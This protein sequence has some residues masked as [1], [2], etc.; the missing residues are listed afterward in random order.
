M[1]FGGCFT[2]PSRLNDCFI[3]QYIQPLL[4]NPRRLQGAMRYLSIGLDFK[5]ID[6]LTEIHARIKVPV[7]FIWGN[8]DPTFPIGAARDMLNDFPS[9]ATMT[10]IE[11]G[12]L[13][14]HEEFPD[15]V[16]MAALK[17]LT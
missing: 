3:A 12:K 7:H 10:E 14:A 15:L 9:G 16:A 13:L 1:G 17:F 8:A 6:S 4:D 2:D 11:G 5:L